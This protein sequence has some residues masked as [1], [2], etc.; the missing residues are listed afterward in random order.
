MHMKRLMVA[1]ATVALGIGTTIAVAAPASAN[2]VWIQQVQ[3]AGADAPCDIPAV[4]GEPAGWSNWA[5]SWAQWPNDGKGGWVCTRSI[6]WAK[7][8]PP[9]GSAG[10][11]GMAVPSGLGCVEYGSGVYANFDGN[12]FIPAGSTVYEFSDCT[13]FLATY[14]F[15]AVYAPVGF[16]ALTLCLAIAPDTLVVLGPWGTDPVELYECSNVT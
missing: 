14:T 13:G 12:W 2:Q 15:P 1:A 5:S 6:T 3:R 9:A 4:A 11:G 8:T 10:G 7:D 16:D